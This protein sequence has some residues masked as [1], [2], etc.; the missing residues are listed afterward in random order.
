MQ[1]NCLISVLHPTRRPQKALAVR[2]DWM[3]KAANPNAIEWIFGVD[4]GGPDDAGLH[5]RVVVPPAT[6]NIHEEGG[7]FC[8]AMNMLA[9]ES[10]G[11]IL[12]QMADDW[13]GPKG[14]DDWIR[15]SLCGVVHL[16]RLLTI[17][18]HPSRPKGFD[19]CCFPCVTRAMVERNGWFYYPE[20]R[21]V[22]TDTDL[23]DQ[24]R[25]D[26]E[27]VD[28]VQPEGFFHDHPM[29]SGAPVDDVYRVGNS[30]GAYAHGLRVYKSRQP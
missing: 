18:D 25:R 24:T 30:T 22:Y 23:S 13:F 5:P 14:W 8:L 26:R 17:V 2:A 15:D 16:P 19:H 28:A 20:Y 6:W 7:T 27:R 29:L 9:K 21:H 12:F 1:G 10:M 3:A 4:E 11:Q